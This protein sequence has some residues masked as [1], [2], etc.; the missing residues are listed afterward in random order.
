[1]VPEDGEADRPPGETTT[2]RKLGELVSTADEAFAAT[3]A[4]AV[5]PPILG[6][7]P[8][9]AATE[10]QPSRGRAPSELESDHTMAAPVSDAGGQVGSPGSS[11]PI[12]PQSNYKGDKEIARGGMGRIIAAEDQR[13][14]RPVALK[15]LIDPAPDQ[16]GRFEREALITARLQHPGIVPVYE[17]GRWPSG[18]PFFA[19]KMVSGRPLDRVIAETRTLQ[20][21]LALLPRIAA[22]ADAMAYAH[23]Q[24]VIHRDLKPGNILI[25][26]FGETVVIDW[27]LAK[28]LDATDSPDSG[29]RMPRAAQKKTAITTSSD[30]PTLTIAGAVMGTPAY[31]APEQA[32]GETL[33]QR[34]DVFALGA[35][36]YHV[37][38][39]VPPYNARTAT[40]VIAS[41]ALGKVVPLLEREKG[42][43]PDLVAIVV[44]AMSLEPAD[45]YPDAGE[46]AEE[47]RRFMTGQLVDAHRYTTLQ[48]IGRFVRK[49]RAAVTVSALSLVLFTVLGTLAVRQI[50][51]QRDAANYERRVADSRRQAAEKLIDRMLSDVKE[52]LQQIGRLDVLSN[53]GGEIR[54]YYNTLALI[55][56][57]M[58]ED[59][60]DRMAI[61]VD[62][63]G[64]AERD[65]GRLDQALKTWT[66]ARARLA[67]I[68]GSD[69]SAK[70]MLRRRMIARFDFSIG[71]VHQQR[72]KVTAAIKAFTQ[73]KS[74]YDELRV[75]APSD[76]LILI[77]A[78]DTHDRLGDL[79]R[80]EG[81]I[82]QALEEYQQAKSDREKAGSQASSRPS[83]E[84]L[85]LSTSHMKLGSVYLARG[86]S[87]TAL[88]SFRA[89]LRLRETLLE[90]QPDNVEVLEKVLEV[91]NELAELQRQIGDDKSAI[92]TYRDA[93][94]VM[95]G[96]ARRDPTNTTWKR[97]RA[98]LLSNLGFAQLDI[99]ELQAG[100]EQ[101]RIATELQKELVARDPKVQ[102][103]QG[104][105]SRSYN[106]SGDGYIYAGDLERG[107]A[108]YKLALEIRAKM[109]KSDPKSAPYRR[110]VAWSHAKL[111]AAYTS[112]L[113]T[114]AATAEHDRALVL[115]TKL[116][117]EAAAHSGF[118]NEL[119]STEIALGKLL[120]RSDAKRAR[121]LIDAGLGRARALVSGD[122]INGEWKETLISGLLA[123]A[124][125]SRA[126]N[127]TSTIV[128]ALEEARTFAKAAADRAPTNAHWPGYV[129]EIHVR[130]AEIATDPK[131]AAAEWKA[132][133]DVLEPL[134]KTGRL[135]AT[136]K[137]LLERARAGR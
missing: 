10:P 29:Q 116:V 19:M 61:A 34:A 130:L 23:S 70:T 8:E 13:L 136:R 57:G 123:R 97:Q 14:H 122:P 109:A 44:R 33:D 118:R 58:P 106:R 65:S 73:A 88:E 85:A 89:A 75:H 64:A 30:S 105:L 26:D 18:E 1:M 42:T 38:A 83:E 93:V 117:D 47:L 101:L 25:G 112:K 37:L 3:M 76:R 115:R 92:Q 46:L 84:V 11:L 50:L 124:D 86:E 49:H 28:D 59:D 95:E 128:G 5:L 51:E 69:A 48:K 32:R 45:R 62:M 133:R 72:G 79:L 135:P 41:A 71:T 78:A 12:V 27:G 114:A 119:A 9:P 66:D 108:M 121:T 111:A 104:D 90:T 82:D 74:E 21:R 55:P 20:D 126:T 35:M 16:I 24:R 60:N 99:G 127:E 7:R 131:V 96:L 137:N 98:Y 54:D 36:L 52:R 103:W 107:I 68:V 87:A 77:G 67:A 100:L 31:M 4:P 39:G 43:P 63:V 94:P 91:Q 102:A 129:A 81:K 120:V 110:A 56:G 17:A 40:D 2:A 6:T 22:A 134:A 132:A 15:E 125:L 53:L 80:N 113:D